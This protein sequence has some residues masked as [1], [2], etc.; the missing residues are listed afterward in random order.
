MSYNGCMAEE[1]ER[2]EDSERVRKLIWRHMGV[3]SAREIAELTGVPPETVLRVKRELL[4]EVDVLS[5]DEKRQ[6]IVVELDEMARDARDRAQG[7]SD[8]FYSSSIQAATGAMKV[9]L[10][11]LKRIGDQDNSKIE[12]LNQKRIQEL[13]NLVNE[14]VVAGVAEIA[15]THGLNEDELLGVFNAKLI[16]AAEGRDLP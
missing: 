10:A 5:I 15:A 12:A 7:M 6:R 4:E 13:V 16:E 1:I 9:V 14:T 11:E 2:T 3:R 8:E